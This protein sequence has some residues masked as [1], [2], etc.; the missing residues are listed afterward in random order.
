MPKALIIGRAGVALASGDFFSLCG[1]GTDTT[2]RANTQIS[3]THAATFSNFRGR[4]VGGNS[5]TATLT[6]EVA[7]AAGNQTFNITGTGTNEDSVN[8][9]V[10][11]AADLFDIAYT[12]TGSNSTPGWW[13]ANIALSTGHGNI[14]GVAAYAGRVFDVASSTR[15]IPL[16]GGLQVDGFSSETTANWKTRGYSTFDALQVR[17]TANARTNDSI[18]RNRIADADGTGVVTFTTGATGVLSDTAI[19]DAITDGQTINASITLNTGVEDLTVS[20]VAATLTSSSNKSESFGG[21]ITSSAGNGVS[22]TASTT[23]NYCTI[24]GYLGAFLTEALSEADARIK[25]GFAAVVSNLRCYLSD[26]T[27]T[28]DGTLKLYQNGSAV[29]TTTITASGGAGWYEN[30]S[31]T[32]TIDADDE[33][34]FEFD[35]GTSGSITI[36]S[37][38]ITFAPV[39]APGGTILPQMMQHGLFLGMRT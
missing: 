38:G 31:N 9:D 10:L 34:S 39:A 29:L 20:F 18:F 17:V 27:Y 35:E 7:G 16:M 23:A 13:A 32:I 1:Y 8:T 36:H 24:G 30:A 6:F 26:N 21:S 28:G 4:I 5:G 15:F 11:A 3:C 14:H 19:G 25:V 12:D 22:R 2:T 33:L 37:V